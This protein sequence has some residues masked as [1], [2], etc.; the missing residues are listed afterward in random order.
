VYVFTAELFPTAARS[1]AL[2]VCNVFSRMGG[3]LS[4]SV[5]LLA[6]YWSP[7]PLVLMG[8]LAVLAGTMGAV[9]P[10]TLGKGMPDTVI[11]AELLEKNE[12]TAA[13]AKT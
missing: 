9:L 8:S 4:I 7:A 11:Q 1:S 3:I 13:T 2:G 10:E 6:A 12:T 5:G